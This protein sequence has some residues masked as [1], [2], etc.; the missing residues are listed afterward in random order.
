VKSKKFSRLTGI[1]ARIAITAA[2]IGFVL[3]L[4][5][6]IASWALGK[7]QAEARVVASPRVVA[8][9]IRNN[10][11]RKLQIGAGDNSKPDWL[12][13]DIEPQSG[14]SYLDAGKPFPLPDRS[15]KY[16]YSEQV[17]EHL[18]YEQGLVMLKESYRVL[19]PGGA[20]R[21]A[22]PN[23][24]KFIALFQESKTPEM[25]DYL[26]AKLRWHKWPRT[27]DLECYILN[28][29]LREWGHQFVYT[30]KMMRASLAAAGFSQIKEFPVGESDDP[31]L[32]NLEDRANWEAS[33]ANAYEA[34]VFQAIR[35]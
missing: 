2:A 28:R 32:R 17:I 9:Y 18:P 24:T 35:E 7:V 13:T 29:Q 19:A 10:A 23:L 31:A 33:G 11:V 3:L 30:P 1:L 6:D 34:M 20:V 12:N 8:D 16:V 27:P 5:P 25:R 15:F 14:Q 26:E 21:L 4:R 22:T